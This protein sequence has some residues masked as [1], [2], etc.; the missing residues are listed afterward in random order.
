MAGTAPS[1]VRKIDNLLTL[2]GVFA[3][4]AEVSGTVVLKF[5]DVNVQRIFV[6]FVMAFPFTLVLLF[7]L[8]LIFRNE[9]LYS[10]AERG[11]DNFQRSV[12]ANHKLSEFKSDIQIDKVSKG[13]PKKKIVNTP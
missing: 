8:V 3:S 2:I 12:D 1:R 9:N 13:K 7:F 5:L 11:R 6:W 4:L 10:P